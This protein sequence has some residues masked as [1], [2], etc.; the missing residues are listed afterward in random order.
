MTALAVAFAHQAEHGCFITSVATTLVA[1]TKRITVNASDISSHLGRGVCDA[2]LGMHALSG[3]DM[4]SSFAGKG[5]RFMIQ[6]LEAWE[7]C[8][9]CGKQ[10]WG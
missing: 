1:R 2:L 7:L 6:T 4:V 9:V 5:Q 8:A 10:A 3:C